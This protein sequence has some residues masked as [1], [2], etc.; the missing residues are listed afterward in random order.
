[1]NKRADARKP[2]RHVL[3]AQ[4]VIVQLYSA[5]VDIIVSMFLRRVRLSPR[6]TL[7]Q[8]VS[9]YT[10]GFTSRFPSSNAERTDVHSR[11]PAWLPLGHIARHS[12]LLSF[13]T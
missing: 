1:L 6:R 9:S 2:Y 8:L 7:E 12:Q 4:N 11:P 13:F 10:G 5:R 3:Y